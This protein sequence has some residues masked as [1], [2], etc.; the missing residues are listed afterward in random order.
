MQSLSYKYYHFSFTLKLELITIT[1]TSHIDFLWKRDQ[2][3]LR[4]ALTTGPPTCYLSAAQH[5]R[6]NLFSWWMWIGNIV[7]GRLWA[8]TIS[9][10]S[11]IF[12]CCLAGG[13]NRGIISTS[14]SRKESTGCIPN[15][16]LWKWNKI[17]LPLNTKLFLA[18]GVHAQSTMAKKILVTHW[19]EKIWF[20]SHNVINCPYLR[21]YVRPPLHVSQ[22]WNAALL[23][24]CRRKV[25]DHK[26]KLN[27]KELCF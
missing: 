15:W 8:F 12:Y 3:K 17:R 26:Q 10:R 11:I 25:N 23:Q 27:N 5:K 14:S 13:W 6:I 19:C 20:Y 21:P 18:E 16:L 9:Y 1:K 22:T 7:F 2:V 4:N 24:V